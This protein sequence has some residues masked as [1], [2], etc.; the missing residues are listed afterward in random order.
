MNGGPGRAGGSGAAPVRRRSR[1]A[2]EIAGLLGAY[3]GPS[4]L[5]FRGDEPG[6]PDA[7]SARPAEGK[8]IGWYHG[9][10]EFGPRALCGRSV[11]PDPRG[12]DTRDRS[13]ASVKMREAFRGTLHLGLPLPAA[14]RQPVGARPEFVCRA[15]SAALGWGH[16]D[17]RLPGS[18][19]QSGSVPPP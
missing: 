17:E 10:E 13:N 19:P 12:D 5:D 3:A 7:V 14:C 9:R 2:E 4:F 16:F 8:V 6:L 11:L 15:G 18:T 1:P